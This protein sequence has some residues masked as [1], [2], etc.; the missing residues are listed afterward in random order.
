[1]PC[2]YRGQRDRWVQVSSGDVGRNIYCEAPTSIHWIFDFTAV[3]PNGS[4]AKMNSHRRRPERV[5]SAKPNCLQW[6]TLVGSK[7]GPVAHTIHSTKPTVRICGDG[8]TK[9]C[10]EHGACKQ[11]GRSPVA[12]PARLRETCIAVMQPTARNR[13]LT[14]EF[15]SSCHKELEG[16][17]LALT[18]LQKPRHGDSWPTRQYRKGARITMCS[19]TSGAGQGCRAKHSHKMKFLCLSIVLQYSKI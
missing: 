13:K 8:A 11:P 18:C 15:C 17:Q 7:K 5:H 12:G 19:L 1:M 2:H 4:S 6:Q 10:E 3:Q 9:H 16:K 14:N